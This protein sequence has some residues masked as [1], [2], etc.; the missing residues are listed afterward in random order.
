MSSNAVPEDAELVRRCG[1]GDQEAFRTLVT[2]YHPRIFNLIH[3]L[4]KDRDEADDLAQEVFIKAFRSLAGFK[5]QAQI[6]TWLYRIAVNRC[7][8]WLKN[9]G[10][11]PEMTLERVEVYRAD[12]AHLQSPGTADAEMVQRELGRALE[13]ALQAIPSDYRVALTLREVDGLSYEEIAEVMECSVGT[14]K[15]R[16]FRARLQLQR[17][18]ADIH[19][20]WKGA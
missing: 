1:E 8:D 19:E 17:M 11:H 18:L 16:L 5:G 15:S 14:V 7:L 12:E 6:Y 13:K 9:R 3:N 4:V 2:R 20:D 10:R